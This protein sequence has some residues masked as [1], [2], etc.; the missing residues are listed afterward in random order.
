MKIVATGN[1]NQEQLRI[2][3]RHID[4]LTAM[5]N[6][7]KAQGAS[8]APSP[9]PPYAHPPSRPPSITPAIK[10]HPATTSQHPP[11][12]PMSHQPQHQPPPPPRYPSYPIVLEFQGQ[13][14]SP[15]RFRFPENAILEFLTPFKMLASFLVIR[16][17][18][19]IGA[20]LEADTEYYEPV[21]IT[22]NVPEG[23]TAARDVLQYI[24]RSVKPAD[25][26]RK[27]M[28]ERIEKCMR[29]QR[30]Y[31]AYRLPQK[32]GIVETEEVPVMQEVKPKPRPA[33]PRKKKEEKEGEQAGG[34]EAGKSADKE[35]SKSADKE[36]PKGVGDDS[37]K[38]AAQ[39]GA[40]V[41]DQ[42]AVNGTGQATANGAGQEVSKDTTDVAVPIPTEKS[43]E[44]KEEKIQT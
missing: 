41:A 27:W 40:K 22:V 2:F 24:N 6:A 30:R 36:A 43:S 8:Q 13:G 5:I 29:T 31:L 39:S 4:E 44:Q 19:D 21:T 25:Q 10:P 17:G 1:A 9:A 37:T 11:I 26:V 42:N 32:S 16:K 38:D 33:A 18:S 34:K 12:Y 23:R 35:I 7:N 3:Q 14:A 28:I 15:D 20:Q